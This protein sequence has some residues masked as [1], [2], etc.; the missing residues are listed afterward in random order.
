MFCADE[1]LEKTL[2]SASGRGYVRSTIRKFGN[3]DRIVY[4]AAIAAIAGTG[5]ET[6]SFATLPPLPAALPPAAPQVPAAPEAAASEED[7][8]SSPTSP[9]DATVFDMLSQ[10]AA[11]EPPEHQEEEL[12]DDSYEEPLEEDEGGMDDDDGTDPDDDAADVTAAIE[13]SHAAQAV[14]SGWSP[15]DSVVF[16]NNA[17][18]MLVRLEHCP[19]IHDL[20]VA[21]L[22]GQ[23]PQLVWQT[24]FGGEQEVMGARVP[25]DPSALLQTA[26][27]LALINISEQL[28]TE[29]VNDLIDIDDE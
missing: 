13:P 3:H 27:D 12:A 6:E 2:N 11:S 24:Y 20:E 4:E 5:H 26:I 23:I 25:A 29:V 18:S 16:V 28:G 17:K 21:R 15:D 10:Y 19:G 9:S 1:H 14:L 8:P 7:A 22:L